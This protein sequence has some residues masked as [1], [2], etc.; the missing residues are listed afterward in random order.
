[1]KKRMLQ[2][3][4]QFFSTKKMGFKKPINEMTAVDD[5]LDGTLAETT[6]NLEANDFSE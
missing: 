2:N 5:D 1:M 3:A 6:T 4:A